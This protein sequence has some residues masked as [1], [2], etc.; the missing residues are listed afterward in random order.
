MYSTNIGYNAH[1][2][3]DFF[4]TLE[5]IGTE[6]GSSIPTFLS[7]HPDPGDRYN[8]VHETAVKYQKSEAWLPADLKV[9]QDSYLKMIDGLVYGEDPRQGFVENSRFIT[10]R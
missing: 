1:M 3:G 2:M 6:S 10:L 4:K 7:T 8:K 9:N 5:A